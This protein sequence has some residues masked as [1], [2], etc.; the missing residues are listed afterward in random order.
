VISLS[1]HEDL[2]E[3][4]EALILPLVRQ[5]IKLRLELVVKS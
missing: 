5:E 3:A 4:L 2:Q 1:E